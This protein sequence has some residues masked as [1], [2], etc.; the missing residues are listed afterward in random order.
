MTDPITKIGDDYVFV[1]IKLIDQ[2]TGL[3]STRR[4][5]KA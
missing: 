2:S 4:R 1:L 5:L 3:F